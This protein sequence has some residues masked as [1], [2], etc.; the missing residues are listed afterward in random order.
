VLRVDEMRVYYD[1]EEEPRAV[2]VIAAVGI[3]EQN[4][5]VT[6]GRGIEP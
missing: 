2:V 4:R 1:V 5:I 6:A 3:K